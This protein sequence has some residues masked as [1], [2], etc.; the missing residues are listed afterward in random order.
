[1]NTLK[2]KKLERIQETLLKIHERIKI[3][4]KQ[5]YILNFA[6]TTAIYWEKFDKENYKKGVDDFIRNLSSLDK[7]SNEILVF[8]QNKKSYA[9]MVYL[10]DRLKEETIKFLN[11]ERGME[12]YLLNYIGLYEVLKIAH[13]QGLL[14]SVNINTMSLEIG[15][16]L[17]ID[18]YCRDFPEDSFNSIM[19]LFVEVACKIDN[20]KQT[21]NL[22]IQLFEVMLIKRKAHHYKRQEDSFEYNKKARTLYKELLK[23]YDEQSKDKEVSQ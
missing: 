13:K 22:W 14:T 6:D 16:E 23:V 21:E 7:Q 18:K 20:E 3:T 9:E 19:S 15:T 2:F 10:F 12:S 17:R 11:V 5:P 1:M 8:I 4:D